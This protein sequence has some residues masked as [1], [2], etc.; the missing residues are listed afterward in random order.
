MMTMKILM[1]TIVFQKIKMKIITRIKINLYLIK[2]KM[3][4]IQLKEDKT[5]TK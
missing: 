3:E 5:I 1:I 2:N 4:Q